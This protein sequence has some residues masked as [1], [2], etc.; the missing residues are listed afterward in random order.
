MTRCPQTSRRARGPSARPT[1]AAAGRPSASSCADPASGD[2]AF[3]PATPSDGYYDPG[4]QGGQ[5]ATSRARW[6][7]G[8]QADP[9]HKQMFSIL[10]GLSMLATKGELRLVLLERQLPD[11]Q[12]MWL[13]VRD[14]RSSAERRVCIDLFDGAAMSSPERSALADNTWKRSYGG[15]PGRPLGLTLN[16]RS[17]EEPFGRYALKSLRARGPHALRL[18]FS[19]LRRL[20]PRWQDYERSPPDKRVGV[21]FQVRAWEPERRRPAGRQGTGERIPSNDDQATSA[22]IRPEIHGGL[23]S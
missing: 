22:G 9:I 20:P 2:P 11:E 16:A 15:G 23:R 12:G 6:Q 7:I 13:E 21:V 8:L 14:E 17:G 3:E 19:A 1:V 5:G 10:A 18:M 4:V